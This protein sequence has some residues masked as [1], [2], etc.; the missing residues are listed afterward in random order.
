MPRTESSLASLARMRWHPTGC[1]LPPAT[2]KKKS[3]RW[4][5]PQRAS[6]SIVMSSARPYHPIWPNVHASGRAGTQL[7]PMGHWNPQPH[8]PPYR[9]PIEGLPVVAY[10]RRG[11]A[12]YFIFH[13]GSQPVEAHV[14]ILVDRNQPGEPWFEARTELRLLRDP[15]DSTET[16]LGYGKTEAEAILASVRLFL[17]HRR[18]GFTTG[19]G[20]P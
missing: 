19:R 8:M 16:V 15:S 2:E 1:D 4:G 11:N 20:T 14:D 18:T 3:A 7:S 10:Q 12:M 9:S 5:F 6:A 17:D 13:W